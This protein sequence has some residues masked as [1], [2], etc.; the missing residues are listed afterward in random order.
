M[1]DGNGKDVRLG[2][3]VKLWENHCGI[4]VCAFDSREF[5]EKYPESGWGHLKKGVL[6]ELDSGD[7][8]H[9]ED[10]DEDF[11]IVTDK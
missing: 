11:E 8:F 5:S 2:D 6:V 1:K 10:P 3:R 9:Y 7:L 4:V